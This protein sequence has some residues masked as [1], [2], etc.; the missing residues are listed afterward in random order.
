M[1]H[2]NLHSSRLLWLGLSVPHLPHFLLSFLP[3]F[4]LRQGLCYV[5]LAVLELTV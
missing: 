1:L 5:A 2:L 4:L 3:S